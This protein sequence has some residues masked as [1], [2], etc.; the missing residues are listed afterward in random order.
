MKTYNIDIDY[1][2]VFNAA[3]L[4]HLNNMARTQIFYGGSS[5][6]KS[7]FVAQ[8]CILDMLHGGRNYLVLRQVARTLRVSVFTQLKRVIEEWGVRSLFSVNKSEMTITCINGYQILFGGLDDVEKLKS[9]VPERGSIT[10]IWI[11]EATEAEYASVKQLYK[12]QR[13]G[14]PRIPK[15]MTL[16][17]NPILQSNWIYKEYFS[18]AKITDAQTDYQS[19]ELSILKTWYIHNKFLT[20]EDV[21]DLE[22]EQDSY[23]YNVYTLGNWGVLSGTIFTNWRVEDL[24]KMRAQFT[25][26]RYGLDFGFSSD[27]A[28]LACM[29]YDKMRKTIYFFDELYERGLTNDMLAESVIGKAGRNRVVCDSAE[30]KS[31]AEL[32]N[33]GVNAIAAKKGADSVTFGVQW[34]QQHTLIVDVNAI[35]AKNEFST[36]HWKTDRQGNAMRVPADRDNHYIDAARY[37]L[38]DD[39]TNL[40]TARSYQG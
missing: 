8:R 6:G 36:Y 37:G 1:K 18:K 15:R 21:K 34:M 29:H 12:R 25:N 31:I 3:Y 10:D 4:P 40:R 39:M 38:E 26:Q 13:G 27:P 5:S 30:P 32:R 16:T 28:A 23:Y 20:S 11:E 35:N 22:N 7:M 24:S 2:N 14:D 33:A 19:D 17:F 9:I